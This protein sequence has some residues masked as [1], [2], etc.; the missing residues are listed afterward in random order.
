MLSL[1]CVR[2][3]HSSIVCDDQ[4]TRLPEFMC[5]H[6]RKKLQT[7]AEEYVLVCMHRTIHI[8]EIRLITKI[9]DVIVLIKQA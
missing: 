1:V 5:L 9:V 4:L 2:L 7:C 6:R 3:I 8:T